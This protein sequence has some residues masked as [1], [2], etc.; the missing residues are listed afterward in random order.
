MNSLLRD[1]GESVLASAE[2]APVLKAEVDSSLKYFF[3]YLVL[4]TGAALGF[5]YFFSQFNAAPETGLLVKTAAAAAAFLIIVT[6][7]ILFIQSFYFN[8]VLALVEMGG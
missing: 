3:I 1:K 4:G 2:P 8:L 6:F 7:Q 5:S